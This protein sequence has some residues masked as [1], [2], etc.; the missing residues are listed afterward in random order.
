VEKAV[1]KNMMVQAIR[2]QKE[3]QMEIQK[4]LDE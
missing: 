4:I 2:T 1:F 3:I